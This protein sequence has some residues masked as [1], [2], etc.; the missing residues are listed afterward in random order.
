MRVLVVDDV[1]ANRRF[2]TNLLEK[3][4]HSVQEAEDGQSA[5][6]LLKS[7]KF[8]CVISDVLMPKL[9]G[10]RLCYKIRTNKSL[11]SIRVFL[12]SSVFTSEN[13]KD[14]AKQMGA[15]G[16]FV[17]PTSPEI[18]LAAIES[19]LEHNRFDN[20][21]QPLRKPDQVREYNDLFVRTLENKND[22]LQAQNQLLEESR[23]ELLLYKTA[24]EVTSVA[25]VITDHAGKITWA[26]PAY[27]QLSGLSP[28][29]RKGRLLSVLHDDPKLKAEIWNQLRAGQGWQGRHAS[30][31][32]DG[33]H[34]TE[35]DTITPVLKDG[36]ITQIIAIISNITN[37]EE[38]THQLRLKTALMEAQIHS[39]PEP[40]IIIDENGRPLI[41]NRNF[42]EMWK[43]PL[44]VIEDSSWRPLDWCTRQCAKP[45]E[46]ARQ[47]EYLWSHAHETS[48]TTIRLIDGRTVMVFAAPVIGS[49]GKLYGRLWMFTDI[50]EQSRREHLLMVLNACMSSLSDEVVV[51]ESNF[52]IPDGPHILFVNKAF[53]RQH[54]KLSSEVIGLPLFQAGLDPSWFPIEDLQ[55]SIEKKQPIR[56]GIESISDGNTVYRDLDII[57]V[58]DKMGVCTHLAFIQRDKTEEK[59]AEIQISEQAEFLDKANEAILVHDLKGRIIFWN[60]GAEKIYGW[61]RDEVLGKRV[62]ENIYSDETLF[63]GIN[64]IT[65]LKGEWNGETRHTTKSK[66][67]ITVQARCTL[68]RDNSGNPKSV[69]AINT[70]VTE[71]KKIESHFMRAQRMESIGTLAGG[72]AHDL[73]NILAPILLSIAVL[74]D[75]VQHPDAVMILE[76]IEVSTRRGADIVRQVVSFARGAEGQRI[77]LQVIHVVRDLEKIIKETFPKDVLLRFIIGPE[78]WTVI[79]DATQL[80]QVLLNLCVNARDAMPQGGILKLSIE[81]TVLDEQ[82]IETNAMSL[83]AGRYVRITVADSGTG[84]RAEHIDKIFEPFFSTKE[85]SKGTGL[86]L[87]TVLAI[88]KS[89][90]GAIKVNSEY[91][92]GASFFVYLPASGLGLVSVDSV[93]TS[94]QLLKGNGELILVVDDEPS[95]LRVTAQTLH[96]NNYQ[97][98]IASDGAEALAFYAQRQ[99]E[100]ALVFTDMMMPV[101][102]GT[103]MIHAL[104]RLNPKVKVIGASG[105][106]SQVASFKSPSPLLKH[107][108]A[109]PFAAEELLR[110]IK[111]VLAE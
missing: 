108:L 73:N 21:A 107:F 106:S 13:D 55:W 26:N 53:E 48:E 50:T 56:R 2:L 19:P 87:S 65:L 74:K 52:N 80:H 77:E 3:A 12:L 88:I 83:P 99:S 64:E 14:L 105:V 15:D 25:A 11:R 101:L 20:P 9:D 75:M 8:D 16:F 76:A 63:H 36:V 46:F 78:I 85:V 58:S 59:R 60:K 57:P 69:L 1:P 96:S 32:K 67:E 41:Y 23:S 97:T 18:I 84:I 70:D 7:R 81:N 49:E 71:K 61:S 28:E 79:G 102:D 34:Y 82:F 6:D 90:G 86:G 109:K 93:T 4:L 24:L 62:V 110:A 42:L 33:T 45:A 40:V 35:E 37:Q 54:L 89:H 66:G 39:V 92:K 38:M 68:I 91:G 111:A 72:I 27:A 100:I 51:C 10:Y 104:L 43:I 30:R 98:I 47:I 5:F 95:I 17:R 44:N 103:A 29:E 94:P 22:E 31:R